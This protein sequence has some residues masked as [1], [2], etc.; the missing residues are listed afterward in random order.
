[1]SEP[2]FLGIAKSQWVIINSF[3]PWFSAIGTLTAVAVSLYLANRVS[4]PRVQ[5]SAGYRIMIETGYKEP[6]PEFIVIRAVNTG[7]RTVRVTQIGWKVG[8]CKKRFA[9][10]M[11]DP[12][13]SSMLPIE[14]SHGQEAKWYIPLDLREEPWLNRFAK[15]VLM[16]CYRTSCFTLRAQ[17]FLSLGNVFQTRPEK[18]LIAKMRSVCEGLEKK[19]G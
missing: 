17:V 10:Q 7:D 13:V 2:T 9:V 14:L 1:M 5:V 15:Q 18:T 6:Y 19:T 3:A 11:F 12:S 4:R 8:L 16:P